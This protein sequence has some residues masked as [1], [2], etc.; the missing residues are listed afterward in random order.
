[1]LISLNWLKQFVDF[2]LP[3]DDL[4]E[5]LSLAGLEVEASK[6]LGQGL[7][8]VFTATVL[9]KK[10]HP[11]AD[12]LSLCQ[13]RCGQE[14]LSIVCGA[15]NVEAGARV[16]LARVGAKLPNGLK[17]KESKI[18]GELS[19]GM[20]ASLSELGLE[21][22]SEGIWILPPSI[23]EGK[24]II[25][26]LALQD[27]ILEVNVTPNRGDCLSIQGL[28]R[29]VAAIL[30]KPFSAPVFPSYPPNS[31][32]SLEIDN[33]APEIC[34]RY[35]CRVLKGVKVGP[36]PLEVQLKLKACG[37]RPIN[38][39]VDTTNE[40][41][42]E[43]GQPLHAFDLD[44]L[45]G[46]KVLIRFAQTGEKLKTLD[47][48]ERQLKSQDL[49]IADQ[50]KALALA[51]IMGGEESSVTES[52]VNLLLESAHFAPIPIRRSAK[53]LAL[54][55]DSSYRFERQVDPAAT[56]WVLEELSR[57]LIERAS[58]QEVGPVVA[59]GEAPQTNLLSLKESEIER[60]LGLKISPKSLEPKLKALGLEFSLSSTG[61]W[62][63]K[64]PSFR[65]D[66]T[67]PIDLIEE[68]ARL[69]GYD[70]IEEAFIQLSSQDLNLKLSNLEKLQS[71]LREQFKAQ[72]YDECLHYSFCSKKLLEAYG[73]TADASAFLSNPLSE[74]WEVM[75]PALFPQ[76]LGSVVQNSRRGQERLRLYEL[77]SVYGPTTEENLHLS[78]ALSGPRSLSHFREKPQMT[79]LLD[80]K[81]FLEEIL[82]GWLGGLL[83]YGELRLSFLHPKRQ[84][85]LIWR[86]HSGAPAQTLGFLGQ[87]HPQWLLE[88]NIENPVSVAE[89]DLAFLLGSCKSKRVFKP[90]SD[91][92]QVRRDLNLVLDQKVSQSEVAQ[93]LVKKGGSLL[94][95][96]YL[97]DLYRGSPLQE[98]QKALTYHLT[99]GSDQRS[100]TDEE[101]NQ[102]R[103]SLLE[104][105]K[106]ACGARLRD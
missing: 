80:L 44:Q 63:F 11:D 69:Y 18:R 75:R 31:S 99:Y 57:R 13:V 47:G 49:V 59:Y 81:G 9:E 83:S 38:N 35:F 43:T 82:L 42:L 52:T 70:K 97:K 96:W 94:Q 78:L 50:T 92:P 17:I 25:E 29:E 88:K 61:E 5:R 64:I 62:Q 79:D 73:L 98:G 84:S 3:S 76:L 8:Q 6:T 51:G 87:L 66:L 77:R 33:Q 89:I 21:E 36:S 24:A 37:L 85:S 67:R 16:A 45:E 103:E 101:V 60:Y 30:S 10:S 23:E 58:V 93:V 14:T 4:A 74:N 2:D 40:L 22:K 15:K 1:M 41:M 90:L 53:R 86:A 27:E 12:R 56:C 102:A 46:S 95:S 65:S 55:T 26:V 54:Q 19:Q 72:A 105:L 34:D 20:L 100:L 91:Y 39:V 7:D 71:Y 68:I 32:A 28:A 106:S 48:I 104:A